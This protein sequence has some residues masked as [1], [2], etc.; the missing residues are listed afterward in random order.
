[1][2][3]STTLRIDHRLFSKLEAHLFPGDD[4]EH[5]AIL[6]VGIANTPRGTRLLARELFLAED[7]VDYVPG[8][9]GYRAL[10]AGFVAEKVNHCRQNNLGYLAIHCHRGTD[11]V[12]F[13]GDDIRSHE[14]GYP[15]LL[16]IT[17]GGPIGALVFAKNAVSGDIWTR[18]ARVD[19][20]A[21]TVVGPTIR[22]LHPSPSHRPQ[23]AD[24][25]YDRHSLL[26]GEVGQWRLAQLKVGIIGLGGGGSLVNEMLGRLGV[27]NIVAIDFD[28]LENTNLPRVVG[29]SRRDCFAWLQEH[30]SP[31]LR[32]IGR[33]L[34]RK[35]VAIARRVAV[36]ANPK[37]NYDAVFGSILDESTARSVVDADFIFLAT[38][39]IQS[40]LVFNAIVQQYLI[41]GVQIGTKVPVE[42]ST[43]EVGNITSSTRLVIPGQGG[44][45]LVCQQLVPGDNL[46]EEALSSAE[47][48]NQRYVDDPEVH[49]PSVITL[50]ALSAAQA[51]NDL[52]MMF[53]GLYEEDVQLKQHLNFVRSRA[54]KEYLPL[55]NERCPW[56]SAAPYSKFA[57]G[58]R[59][60]LPCRQA[61]RLA[62]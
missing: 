55:A 54:L 39:N 37:V 35:K 34:A 19:L 52:M 8:T 26:F 11:T 44:G 32:A 49:A 59:A 3:T 5:A 46:Q 23:H 33:R 30:E 62:P 15:A 17:G 36:Q 27:G 25:M 2:N 45:C 47:R 4:D 41:P 48:R 9:Y 14:R 16:D 58:D 38:D 29:S 18:D 10:A 24:P 13:S 57:R 53:T 61:S 21:L 42:Q 6:A 12:S 31:R 7:G 50:N 22:L 56:C 20:S 51:A 60:R 43:K 1:M 40:R 28:R